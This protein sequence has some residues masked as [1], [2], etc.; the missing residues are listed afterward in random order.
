MTEM[1]ILRTS[2]GVQPVDESRPV[3]VV[4]DAIVDT[5]SEYTWLPAALLH[6]MGVTPRRT[7]HF[8]LADGSVIEREMGYAIIH[9]AGTAAPDL[10]VFALEGDGVLLGA[11]SIEG[12]NLKLDLA[13][14]Q[15]VP[16]GPV[17]AVMVA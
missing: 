9:A 17:L 2:I 8:Q 6:E 15:L 14:R 3:R 11:H 13:R 1:G 12:M 16:G 7:Q 10:V 5:G 4:V